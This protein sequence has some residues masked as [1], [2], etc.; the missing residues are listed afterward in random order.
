[1]EERKKYNEEFKFTL[2]TG[3]GQLVN[4]V[5]ITPFSPSVMPEE[6][7]TSMI[8]EMVSRPGQVYQMRGLVGYRQPHEGGTSKS[9]KFELILNSY[10][11]VEIEI[12]YKGAV[13]PEPQ[14]QAY[15]TPTF[16]K[17]L[18]DRVSPDVRY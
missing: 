12:R 5:E 14:F 18:K 1:M 6:N 13:T 11:I 3:A 10:S 2:I 4:D 16:K 9:L 7:S 17:L 15:I 8:A